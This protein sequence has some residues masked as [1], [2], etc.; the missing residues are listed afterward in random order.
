MRLRLNT[1]YLAARLFYTVP[2]GVMYGKRVDNA[3]RRFV[4]QCT[5]SLSDAQ[6]DSSP[7]VHHKIELGVAGYIKL[8][9]ADILYCIYHAYVPPAPTSADGLATLN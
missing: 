8:A 5:S 7:H 3:C 1:L 4:E 6:A 2:R 9:Y